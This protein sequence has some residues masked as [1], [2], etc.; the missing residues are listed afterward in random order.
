MI[1]CALVVVDVE[2]S[3]C[4]SEQG[5]KAGRYVEGGGRR[6]E[7]RGSGDTWPE[8]PGLW[9]RR[10]RAARRGCNT[11][12]ACTQSR[13]VP[14]VGGCR[15]AE[16]T[17][18]RTH[19]RS[20]NPI[21]QIRPSPLSA[22]RTETASTHTPATASV[23]ARVRAGACAPFWV[24]ARGPGAPPLARM[25]LSARRCACRRAT[26]PRGAQA[27]ACHMG[28]AQ[29]HAAVNALPDHRAICAAPGHRVSLRTTL[30]PSAEALV[31]R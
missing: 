15:C 20:R 11:G 27:T 1:S 7:E 18:E 23:Q 2:R 31:G 12:R 26:T 19:A 6:G 14:P 9:R 13:G 30:Q 4:N 5:Q 17:H 10:R 22:P 3:S 21:P 24:Q 29:P 28:R 16:R 25:R 8:G